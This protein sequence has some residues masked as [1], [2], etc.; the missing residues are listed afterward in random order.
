MYKCN[1]IFY[2]KMVSIVLMIKGND[3]LIFI[4]KQHSSY[5]DS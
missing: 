5:L 4:S 2:L 3:E 1:N